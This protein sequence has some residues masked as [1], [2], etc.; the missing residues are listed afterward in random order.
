MVK[1]KYIILGAGPSGLTLG[2]CLKNKGENDFIIIEKESEAGG[3]CRSRNVDG[4]PLDIGGGHFLDVRN[5]EV[6]DFLFDFLPEN[7]WN[8]FTRDSRIIVGEYEIGHPFEANIWQ[9]PEQEQVKYLDSIKVAGCNTGIP[10]PEKF[11]DWI[12]W[13]LGNIIAENYML[14]YNRKMFSESLDELGTYWLNKLPNVSYEETLKSCSERKSYGTQPGHA[15]FYYPKEYGYGE[16]FKRLADSMAENV[17]Y[18][19]IVAEIDFS[20]RIVSCLNGEKYQSDMIITTIPWTSFLS[21]GLPDEVIASICNLK[22]SSTEIR[23]VNEELA[24]PAHW[25]YI[26]DEAVP[27][28]RILC[29]KNFCPQSRGYWVETNSERVGSYVESKWVDNYSYMNEYA[30][31]LN[32]ITKPDIMKRLL[33]EAASHGVIGLGRWGEHEHYNSDVVISKAIKLADDII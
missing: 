21:S 4:K 3:L 7:E 26:P 17:I 23:Y 27:Y 32:T 29:R 12:R 31:P 28:H 15:K 5:P 13:K 33:K 25:I 14:P 18:N 9:L 20:S 10:Q 22:H 24:S 1:T 11:T 19:T 2:R 30:Y 16:V 6:C 8:T